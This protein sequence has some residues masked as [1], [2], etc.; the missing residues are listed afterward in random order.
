MIK[1]QYYIP[2]KEYEWTKEAWD[3]VLKHMEYIMADRY[4]P[5]ATEG[6]NVKGVSGY[7]CEG[8][9]YTDNLSLC[10]EFVGNEKYWRFSVSEERVEIPEYLIPFYGEGKKENLSVEDL[11]VG[12]E[13]ILS[14]GVNYDR[15]VVYWGKNQEVIFVT[16]LLFH[17]YG[18]FFIKDVFHIREV[19]EKTREE[20]LSE[21]Y[22][23]SLD[24]VNKMVEDGVII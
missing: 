3:T 15:G 22:G 8:K 6:G 11:E 1:K 4:G 13:Y 21:K 10:W 18:H 16:E 24:K 7:E 23:I 9:S 19:P 20:K 12:K 2:G 17:T 5:F 14:L